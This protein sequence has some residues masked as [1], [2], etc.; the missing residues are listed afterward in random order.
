MRGD[1]ET[2]A[3]VEQITDSE[4]SAI[5]HYLDPSPTSHTP[6][7]SDGTLFAVVVCVFMFLIT[8]FGFISLYLRT[9]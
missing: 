4:V 1:H 2:A 9:C 6:G 7:E 3:P 8:A 5:I